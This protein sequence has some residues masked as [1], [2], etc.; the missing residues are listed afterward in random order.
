[1]RSMIGPSICAD[2]LILIVECLREV[3]DGLDV[4]RA[5]VP[6]QGKVPGSH[7]RMLAGLRKKLAELEALQNKLAETCTGLKLVIERIE[8]MNAP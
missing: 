3:L 6:Q 5:L 2:C 4:I 1:M 8:D 7:D